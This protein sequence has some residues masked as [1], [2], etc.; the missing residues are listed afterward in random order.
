MS[1]FQ[2]DVTYRLQILKLL[3]EHPEAAAAHFCILCFCFCKLLEL[4][5]VNEM[6]LIYFSAS[7]CSIWFAALCM[8]DEN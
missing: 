7:D 4:T 1:L 8:A 5:S 3:F 6:Y 2:L